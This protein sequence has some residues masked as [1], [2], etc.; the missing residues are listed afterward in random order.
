MW[1]DRVKQVYGDDMEVTWKNFSLEQNAFTLKQKSEGTESDWT[2]WGQDDVTQ[3]RSL[4]GQ[5]A[6]EAAR[7]QG[8]ELFDKF[9]L[10]LLTARHGGDGRIAL[11]EEGPLVELAQQ[12]GLDAAKF[13][14]D[15]RDPDLRDSIGT[16]HEAAVSQGIFGTP[17]FVFENGNAAFIKA[18]IP[19]QDDAVSEFEHF[20]ALMNHRSYIGE[21]KR[22][23]PPWPKGAVD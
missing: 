6:A 14:E 21:I 5:I 10:A 15:L 23:Q 7:R 13:R 17:T 11:N 1:L 18:F 19:P 8:T 16:D 3:G 20:V 12:V 22:P 9:H 2:V 4:M